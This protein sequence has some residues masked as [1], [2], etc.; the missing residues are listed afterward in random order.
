MSTEK[1]GW[2]L[3]MK[4]PDVHKYLT[5]KDIAQLWGMAGTKQ[6]CQNIRRMIRTIEKD[7]G[8]EIFS[9][10]RPVVTTIPILRK[11]M[12]E[13]FDRD[14]ILLRELKRYFESLQRRIILLERQN[15]AQGSKIREFGTRLTV[16]EGRC[17]HRD[18]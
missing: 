17:R 6:D 3:N 10:K 11:H 18:T 2:A 5:V 7:R 9:G 16:I 8:I 4:A 1:H 14:D 13:C 12:P 15:G